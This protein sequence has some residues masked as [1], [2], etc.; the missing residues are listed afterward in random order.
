[1]SELL[2]YEKYFYILLRLLNYS[3]KSLFIN[4]DVVLSFIV[5]FNE[6]LN[7]PIDIKLEIL[8]KMF[9]I[10]N[11]YRNLT[12]DDTYLDEIYNMLLEYE[13]K[14]NISINKDIFERFASELIKFD[15]LEFNTIDNI[16]KNIFV[17]Y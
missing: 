9:K 6:H 3:R 16:L 10:V 5:Y 7:L 17:I 8:K 2:E 11:K 12:N 14:F 4:K 13:T 1:M 15:E